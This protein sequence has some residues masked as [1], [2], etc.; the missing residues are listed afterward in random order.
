[1]TSDKA[2][3]DDITLEQAMERLQ[4]RTDGEFYTNGKDKCEDMKLGIEALKWVRRYRP[5]N[6]VDKWS[7]LAGES[8]K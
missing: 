6:K 4:M 7:L 3:G 8:E 5:R 1:M 2:R